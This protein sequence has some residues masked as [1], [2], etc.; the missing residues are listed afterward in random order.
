MTQVLG[1][2]HHKYKTSTNFIPFFKPLTPFFFTLS[3][4]FF[5][6]ESGFMSRLGE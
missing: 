1:L 5:D 3:F 2:K 4:A 6:L